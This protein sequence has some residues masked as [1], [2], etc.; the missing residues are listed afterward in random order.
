MQNNNRFLNA[1]ML[2][3]ALSFGLLF[4]L[5]QRGYFNNNPVSRSAAGELR[6][7]AGYGNHYRLDGKING[8]PVRFLIDTGATGVTL[9]KKLAESLGLRSR[10]NGLSHTANGT[11]THYETRLA[12]LS[13]GDWTFEDVDA[14]IA[15]NMDDEVLLGMRILRHFE[16]IQRDGELILRAPQ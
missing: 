13:I 5:S 16:I 9:N 1:F 12:S 3:I 14:H 6:I 2:I 11:T 8:Q 7:R 15:P 10:G 4:Y